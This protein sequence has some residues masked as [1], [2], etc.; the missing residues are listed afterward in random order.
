MAN[1]KS[2]FNALHESTLTRYT[3]GAGFLAGDVVT[4]KQK[5]TLAS[6][7]FKSK[8]STVQE[9]VKGMF[10][11]DNNLRIGYLH[12][13]FPHAIGGYGANWD[14][15]YQFAD[16]YV[17]IS[18]ANWTHPISVPLDL[19]DR[20]EPKGSELAPIPDSIKDKK[21]RVEKNG[22]KGKADKQTQID[23][24]NRQN[25]TVDT[26][27]PGGKKWDDSKVGGGNAQS[28]PGMRESV[29]IDLEAAYDAVLQEKTVEEDNE[30]L[31]ET[32]SVADSFNKCDYIPSQAGV[33]VTFEDTVY[34]PVHNDEVPVHVSATYQHLA[35]QDVTHTSQW[36]LTRLVVLDEEGR[37]VTIH[38]KDQQYLTDRAE[39]FI[40]RY[41]DH[42][43]DQKAQETVVD[44]ALGNPNTLTIGGHKVTRTSRN[45]GGADP[46]RMVTFSF[47]NGYRVVEF[48]GDHELTDPSGKRIKH[49]GNSAE[50]NKALH[51]LGLP[52]LD[53]VYQ[54]FDQHDNSPEAAEADYNNGLMGDMSP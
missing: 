46:T 3:Q 9:L 33:E 39:D 4:F 44:E 31:S 20:V 41:H 35:A 26:K 14:G 47:D 36:E 52:I 50:M 7:W 5:K 6:E 10:S 16:I 32:P 34:S 30:I 21:V 17:E 22:K 29:D 42:V 53:D 1:Y 27:I 49:T 54:A 40:G 37:P 8:P 51:S 18:P 25:P 48:F 19:L 11:L 24:K 28:M 2:K 15:A 45:T 38:Q 43:D 23:D 12:K 13:E